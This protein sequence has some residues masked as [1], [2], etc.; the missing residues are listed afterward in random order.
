MSFEE[1]WAEMV[2]RGTPDRAVERT[3]AMAAW[4]AALCAATAA[5]FDAGR[6]RDSGDVLR[7]VT[8]LH[9]WVKAGEEGGGE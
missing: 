1:F 3:L 5:A 4:D 8:D 9:S 6:L 7:G 2:G